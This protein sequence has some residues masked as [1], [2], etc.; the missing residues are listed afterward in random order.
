[1]PK[2][3]IRQYSRLALRAESSY[4][5]AWGKGIGRRVSVRR[6]AK[7]GSGSA[8]FRDKGGVVCRACSNLVPPAALTHPG[9]RRVPMLRPAPEHSRPGALPLTASAFL[10]LETRA[11]FFGL[12][13]R[14]FGP[15]GSHPVVMRLKRRRLRRNTGAIRATSHGRW[16]AFLGCM[17]IDVLPPGGGR[18]GAQSAGHLGHGRWPACSR[19]SCFCLFLWAAAF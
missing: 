16:Y 18:S 19:R 15:C 10:G 9:C 6:A 14:Q 3:R 11:L 5:P 4:I 1:M 13:G 17:D 12:Q 8:F 7:A 2:L